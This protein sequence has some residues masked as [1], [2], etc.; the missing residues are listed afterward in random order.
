MG[1]DPDDELDIDKD[2]A[3]KV[4]EET[5]PVA[6]E[7]PDEENPD[8]E[9]K[10]AL[11]YPTVDEIIDIHGDIIEDDPN[12]EPGL[13]HRGDL[14]YTIDHIKHGHFDQGPETVHEKAFQLMRLIAA[15]H[16]FVDGNK[17]TALGSTVY[18]YFWNGYDLE[19]QEELEAMLI[20]MSIRENFVNP[21]IAVDYLEDITEEIDAGELLSLFLESI[22]V[23]TEVAENMQQDFE[24]NDS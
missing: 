24:E 5:S 8:S 2:I 6:D 12:A 16:P 14:E 9:V 3:E 20:L 13:K 22:D 7:E 1:E 18:F 11:F 23:F 19:Y 10:N 21:D 4:E 15:N 17:R